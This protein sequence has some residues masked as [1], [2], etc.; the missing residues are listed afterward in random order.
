[1]TKL[2]DHSISLADLTFHY[3]EAG[4]SGAPPLILL[5][6]LGTDAQ[7]WNEQRSHSP[8]VIT[9]WLSTSAVMAKAPGPASTPLS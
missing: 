3:R 2:T 4:D 8:I 7:D 9:S 6:A 5:H 1:M